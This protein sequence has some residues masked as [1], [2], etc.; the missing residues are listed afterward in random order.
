MRESKKCKDCDF[1]YEL[2]QIR[3]GEEPTTLGSCWVRTICYRETRACKWY[4]RDE[5]DKPCDQ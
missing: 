4:Q 2:G 1:F 5:G 3:T